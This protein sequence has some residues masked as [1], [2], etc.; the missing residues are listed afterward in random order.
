M[1]T[2]AEELL[3]DGM[4]ETLRGRAGG[5]DAANSFF[6][7][8]LADLQDAGSLKMVVPREWGGLGYRLEESSRAQSRLASAA[9]ATALAVNIHL[10]WTG[11]ARVLQAR[12][13]HSLDY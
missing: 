1:P 3:T 2:T 10:V 12:G 4:L 13:D 7:E 9:P 6:H 8:D 5:S 11:V